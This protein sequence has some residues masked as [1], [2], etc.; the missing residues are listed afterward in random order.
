MVLG[1]ISVGTASA[2]VTITLAGDVIVTENFEV[3][4]KST[5]HSS[6]IQERPSG[7]SDN[8]VIQRD[9]GPQS[10]KPKFVLSQR[11]NNENMWIYGHDGSTFKNFMGFD[12]PN[13]QITIPANGDTLVADAANNKVGIGT[14]N[15]TSKLHVVGDAII[16]EDLN[17][18]GTSFNTLSSNLDSLQ[19]NVTEIENSSYVPFYS[20]LGGLKTCVNTSSVSDNKLL[21]ITSQNQEPF[22]VTGVTVSTLG[23]NEASDKIIL[24]GWQGS[25]GGVLVT[26]DDLTASSSGDHM[27][28]E[29]LGVP[30]SSGG[31]FPNQLASNGSFIWISILCDNTDQDATIYLTGSTGITGWKKQNDI[32]QVDLN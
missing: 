3:E 25:S 4:G 19:N 13:Y 7:N 29:I 31:N 27:G 2:L 21:N 23:V 30:L 22:M 24:K 28:Y 5:F 8:V 6:I 16:T 17:V 10:G 11:S 12:F 9:G 15:P 26:S 18:N 14:L 20:T 1:A 32:I